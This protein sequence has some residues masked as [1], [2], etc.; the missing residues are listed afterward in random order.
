[1]PISQ[2]VAADFSAIPFAGNYATETISQTGDGFSA[3]LA[4]IMD[5]QYQPAVDE[6]YD[7]SH[8]P[9]APKEQK[10]ILDDSLIRQK[11]SDLAQRRTDE[12][13]DTVEK[14]AARN[15]G[16][17]ATAAADLKKKSAAGSIAGES[18][19]DSAISGAH[20]TGAGADIVQSVAGSSESNPSLAV[21]DKPGKGQIAEIDVVLENRKP[22]EN[23]PDSE[24][25]TLVE[26]PSPPV[27][28]NLKGAAVRG[29]PAGVAKDRKG[30]S[31]ASSSNAADR[32]VTDT[33][34][35][36][37]PQAGRKTKIVVRDLRGRGARG[38]G[39]GNRASEVVKGADG[40]AT[41]PISG[42]D[43]QSSADH[44]F[45]ALLGAKSDGS[46]A[47]APRPA[48]AMTHLRTNP[49]YCT[50]SGRH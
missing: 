5:T 24:N 9:E 43:S 30:V 14:P 49:A 11:E 16:S 22:V 26:N 23:V 17:P 12:L 19:D 39:A 40:S 48:D 13:T 29:R 18:H 6:P 31:A 4:R 7:N 46:D 35:E 25:L 8:A 45:T 27:V 28:K 50:R 20:A 3:Y 42:N 15:P 47:S 44:S 10:S 34:F 2:I 38:D 41:G 1:M 33:A 36:E 32:A 21:G 37:R